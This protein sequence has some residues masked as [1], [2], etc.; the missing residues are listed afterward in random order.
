MTNLLSLAAAAVLVFALMPLLMTYDVTS[1]ERTKGVNDFPLINISAFTVG[2]NGELQP[3][4]GDEPAG[5]TLVFKVDTPQSYIVV[6]AMSR[7]NEIP[8]VRYKAGQL[9]AGVGQLLRKQSKVYGYEL[10][11]GDKNLKFCAISA[12]NEHKMNQRLRLLTRIW[13]H[14]PKASCVLVS[15]N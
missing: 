6:L 15:A 2:E 9:Q 7:G 1:T 4:M 5:T 8:T 13:V 14:L 11:S 10:D 3:A 12:E